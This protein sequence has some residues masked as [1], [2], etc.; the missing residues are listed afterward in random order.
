MTRPR[1]A[2][3]VTF[4]DHLATG[5]AWFRRG[6]GSVRSGMSASLKRKRSAWAW[7]SLLP[8]RTAGEHSAGFFCA[9]H[10]RRPPQA[11]HSR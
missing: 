10:S 3:V 9:P 5:A 6:V 2:A 8:P 7:A 11:S 1:T 4:L